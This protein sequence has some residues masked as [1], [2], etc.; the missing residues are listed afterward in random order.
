MLDALHGIVTVLNTPFAEDNSIDIAG[1]QRN[2]ANALQAGIAGFLIPALASEVDQL[3]EDEKRELVGQVVAQCRGRAV[4]IGGASAESQRERLGLAGGFL[5]LGCD[6]ILIQW[7]SDIDPKL[8]ERNMAEIV[9]L[10][11][12]FLMLQDWDPVGPGIPM[13]TLVGL[14]ERVDRFDWLK[15]E[16]QDAGPKYSEVLAAL[17]GK[18]RVAGGWAVTRM[19]DGLDRGVHLFMPTAMHRIYVEIYQRRASGDREG[20]KQLFERIE[21]VLAFSNQRLD[22]SIRFFKRLLHAQGVY[23][24]PNVRIDGSAFDIEQERMADRL[25]AT[26]TSIENDLT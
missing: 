21:P 1:L 8:M 17:G 2:V 23:A 22:I 7:N 5:E 15:I 6:G 12:K 19:I 9:E 14:F 3:N 16:V 10:G 24:T 20:A 11:P 18:L 13:A 4:V 25:I 26:V